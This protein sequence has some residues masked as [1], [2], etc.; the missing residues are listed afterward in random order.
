MVCI[1]SAKKTATDLIRIHSHLP[2]AKHQYATKAKHLNATKSIEVQ[3]NKTSLRFPIG[4]N[5]ANLR[6][7]TASFF[8]TMQKID[9]ALFR[10]PLKDREILSILSGPSLPKE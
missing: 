7:K 1:F 2:P 4:I 3:V 10:F 9:P 5:D 6:E 8:S